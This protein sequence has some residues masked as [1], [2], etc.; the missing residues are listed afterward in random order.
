MHSKSKRKS[1]HHHRGEGGGGYPKPEPL[2]PDKPIAAAKG[3]RF[4]SPPPHPN[5]VCLVLGGAVAVVH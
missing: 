2:F 4:R 1:A 3:L 5:P